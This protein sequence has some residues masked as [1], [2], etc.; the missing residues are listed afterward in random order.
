VIAPHRADRTPIRRD[1]HLE[2]LRLSY[3]DWPGAEPPIVLLHPNR[4]H[5]RTW[6]FMVASSRVANR[7]VAPDL[8]GHGSSDWPEAGYGL[9]DHVAD[10]V[11]FVETLGVAPAVVMGAATG[12]TVALL[13]ASSRPD[14][15]AALAVADPGLSLDPRIGALV[16]A[17]LERRYRFAS[18]TE[19]RD[20]L[21]FSALWSEAVREHALRHGLRDVEGGGSAWAYHR[22]GAAAIET[23]LEQDIWGRISVACPT[24][25]LRGDRSR[26][27]PRERMLRL[28]EHLDQATLV[29][30]PRADHRIAQDNPAFAA[31]ALDAF[32]HATEHV[33]EA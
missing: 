32:L 17:D 13:L 19:A 7:F 3:V 25:V 33:V 26:V 15:V 23:A 11:A 18:A 21:P 22:D 5:A 9:E 14:L 31:A 10:V 12:G 27:F 4:A 8:R 29:E 24:M 16:R 30:V 6:D 2:R 28:L 20:A 1:A